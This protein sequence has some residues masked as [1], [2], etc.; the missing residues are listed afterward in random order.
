MGPC[1]AVDGRVKRGVFLAAAIV[2]T[3][4]AVAGF[5]RTYFGPLVAGAIRQPTVIHIHAVVMVTWLILFIA[6]V[7][8]AASGRVR[9]HVRL[10]WWVM[11][12][13]IVLVVVA[14]LASFEGFASRLATGDV[15]R[16]QRALFGPSVMSSSS[17]HS[18]L[19]G[20]SIAGGPRFTNG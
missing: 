2:A 7:W 17:C 1:G 14:L 18:S 10:G 8:F 6:Q 4:L 20:G 5:W 16:A 12:Y 19:P 15:F 3:I 11:G 13:G 9:L